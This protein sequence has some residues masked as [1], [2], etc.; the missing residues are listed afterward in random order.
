MVDEAWSRAPTFALRRFP[1]AGSVKRARENYCGPDGAVFGASI[2]AEGGYAFAFSRDRFTFAVVESALRVD[3]NV[4]A[5][6]KLAK[7]P[8]STPSAWVGACAPVWEHL[9]A[10]TISVFEDKQWLVVCPDPTIDGIPIEALV[11]PEAKSDDWRTLP[12]LMQRIAVGRLPTTTLAAEM[13][14]RRIV[15][16][17]PNA[18][19]AIALSAKDAPETGLPFAKAFDRDF[20]QGASSSG[21]VAVFKLGD[22]GGPAAESAPA[23]RPRILSFGYGV[24]P[25]AVGW[26]RGAP[27]AICLMEPA[28]PEGG[29]DHARAWMILGARAVIAPSQPIDRPLAEALTAG[30]LRSFAQDGS[31]PVEAVTMAKRSILNTSTDGKALGLTDAHYHPGKWSCMQAWLAIP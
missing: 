25:D 3:E 4:A 10:S 2:T 14:G 21:R 18:F 5:L 15:P 11:P 19:A 9:I 31:N 28:A 23:G 13:R 26:E 29:P 30:I 16:W 17:A 6:A 22:T 24:P 7:D 27:A 20:A 8:R 12:Y 1:R